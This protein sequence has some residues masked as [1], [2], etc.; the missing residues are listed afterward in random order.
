M[1]KLK[2]PTLVSVGLALGLAAAFNFN[3]NAGIKGD[4]VCTKVKACALESL[5]G[6]D[7]AK[8]VKDALMAQLDSQCA[9]SFSG[10]EKE[11]LEA[12]LE[13]QANACADAMIAMPCETLLTPSGA[14]SSKACKEFK[15]A[16][17]KAG[18]EG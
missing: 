6:Q 17:E 15:A 14:G 12:G 1:N 18:I 11:L 10:K 7:M 13:D 5:E 16:S 9:A 3:A 2:Y 8:Q 4:E